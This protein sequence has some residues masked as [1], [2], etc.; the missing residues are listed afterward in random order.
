MVHASEPERNQMKKQFR[1]YQRSGVYYAEGEGIG[2]GSGT[3]A[4]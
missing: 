2:E 1:L 3:K 4:E